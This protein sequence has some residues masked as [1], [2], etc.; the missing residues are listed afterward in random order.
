TFDV[1]LLAGRIVARASLGFRWRRAPVQRHATRRASGPL[2]DGP[3]TALNPP[4]ALGPLADAPCPPYCQTVR[5]PSIQESEH[6][7]II[8]TRLTFPREGRAL[9]LVGCLRASSAGG[10]L[11]RRCATT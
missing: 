1:E 3:C 10:V 2:A 8:T 11:A 6:E 5:N 9:P 7:A 4:Q